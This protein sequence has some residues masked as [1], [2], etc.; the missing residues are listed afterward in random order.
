MGE[1]HRRIS[2]NFETTTVGAVKEFAEAH[3]WTVRGFGTTTS[4]TNA[5]QNAGIES[6]TIARALVAPLPPKA[7]HELW[8]VDE[9]SL[10]AT[11]NVN[12]LLKLAH[13]CTECHDRLSACRQGMFEQ[14][15]K[16]HRREVLCCGFGQQ[17]QKG[18]WG[19]VGQ[20]L[21]S[22]VVDVDCPAPK[23]GRDTPRQQ[24][25]QARRRRPSG[26]ARDRAN[27]S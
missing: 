27:Q 25:R 11:R 17:E 6:Q 15:K 24:R 18:A 12:K 22:A 13:A 10:L 23:L 4:S 3:G 20:R 9:S 19:R 14:R 1:R 21:A 5:L 26:C 2:W 7:Q 16:R 8:I